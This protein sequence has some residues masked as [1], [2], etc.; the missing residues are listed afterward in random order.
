[1]KFRLLAALIFPVLI[2][3][4]IPLFASDLSLP[5]NSSEP[6][7]SYIPGDETRPASISEEIWEKL[8]SGTLTQQAETKSETQIQTNSPARTTSLTQSTSAL[9]SF[10]SGYTLLDP[11][12]PGS[13][14]TTWETGMNSPG[15]NPQVYRSEIVS[16][17]D[18]STALRQQV[19]GNTYSW[20]TNHYLK[21]TFNLGGAFYPASKL[22]LYLEINRY[23][24]SCYYDGT[25]LI[26]R[27]FRNGNEVGATSYGCGNYHGW[28]FSNP[29]PNG[30]TGI[31]EIPFNFVSGT[32]DSISIEIANYC[33][34]GNNYSI[35]DH[36]M[37][38]GD[39]PVTVNSVQAIPPTL[40]IGIDG[41]A[42]GIVFRAATSVSTTVEFK[43]RGPGGEIF[44]IGS[45]ATS[46]GDSGHIAKLSWWGNLGGSTI[47]EGN[48]EIIAEAGSSSK[49]S[50]F[51][52]KKVNASI[53]GMGTWMKNSKDPSAD[54]PPD[55]KA[56]Q[57]PE[58]SWEQATGEKEGY[59]AGLNLSDPVNI[60]SGNFIL[61]NVDLSLKS[62]L[63]LTLA[64]IY[65]SL[66][67]NIGL[68][69]RGWSSPYLS[70]LEF[71]ASDVV[72]VNSDGSKSFFKYSDGAYVGHISSNLQLSVAT[73]TNL[74]RLFIPGG[75]EWHFDSDGKIIRMAKACCGTGAADSVNIDYNSS[76]TLHKV[77]NNAGQWL[78]FALNSS[79]LIE[80]VT[81][82]AGRTLRYA[83]DSNRNLISFT[84]AINQITTYTYNEDNFL[85]KFTKPGNRA[86][87][88]AYQGSR[89]SGITFPNAASALFNWDFSQQKLLFTSP[90]GVSHEYRFDSSW[91]L[92]GYEIPNAGISK[93]FS[94][95]ELALTNTTNSLG[96]MFSYS[97]NADG[98]LCTSTDPLGNTTSYEWHP[99]FHKLAKKTDP[100]NREWRYNW[101]HRGNL[102]SEINPAGGITSY[103]YDAHNNR[104]SRTDPLGRTVRY[105][106]SSDGSRLLRSIDALGGI[107]S[108]SYDARSNLISSSDQL[109]RVTLY[110]Y[111]ALDRLVKTIH[112]DGRWTEIEYDEAGNIANRRDNLNRVTT[113]TY[114]QADKMISTTRPDGTKH[115]YEYNAAGKKIAEINPLGEKTCFEYDAAGNLVRIVYPDDSSEMSSY[116]TEGQLI[117]RTNELGSVT[118]FEYDPL[119]RMVA[120]IDP[121][122]SR[123][124]QTYDIAGRKVSD[125]DPLLHTTCYAFDVLDRVVST[126]KPDSA[127]IR[128]EYDAVGNLLKT[129]DALAATWSWQYD[130]L[131]RQVKAIQPNGATSETS[132]DAAGQTSAEID[133]LVGVTR[134]SYDSA[135]RIVSRT[136][137]LGN[138]WRNNYDTAGRLV[139]TVNPLGEISSM[140]FDVMDCVISESN[141]AGNITSYEFDAV[142]RRVA[143]TDA[144]GNRSI[145]AYDSRGRVISEV[146]AEGRI[147]QYDYDL[148]GSRTGLTDAACRVWR[149]KFDANGRTLAEIDPIGNRTTYSYNETGARTALVNAR[150][151]ITTFSFDSMNRLVQIDYPNGT[152][153]T[154]S[155]DLTGRELSRSDSN[156]LAAKKYDASGNLISEEFQTSACPG[157]SKSWNYVYDLA[158]NR[159]SAKNPEEE[160]FKY[161]YDALNRLI[162]LDPPGQNNDIKYLYDT[163]GKQ[164]GTEQPGVNTVNSFDAAGRLLSVSHNRDQKSKP[165]ISQR[166]YTYNALGNCISMTDDECGTTVY[167]YDKS[168]WLI[169]VT[170]PEKQVVSYTYNNAGD[171]LSETIKTGHSNSRTVTYSYDAAGRMI[172]KASDTF[173][174][175]SDGNLTISIEED[176]V[177]RNTWSHDNRLLKIEREIECSKHHKKHCR[178]CPKSFEISEEYSYLPNDWRRITRKTAETT[179]FSVY[180]GDDESNEYLIAPKSPAKSWKFGPF[181]WKPKLPQLFS[182]REFISGPGNDDIQTTNYH[183]KS[184][185]M[186]KDALGSTIALT[187]RG[188]NTVAKINYDAWG[189][190]RWP[191]K[192]GHNIA[193][194]KE[195]DLSDLLDRLEGR[196]SFGNIQ[197]DHWH[198][199]RHFAKSFTPYLYTGRRLSAISEQ[200][201]NRNRYY[202]PRYGRFISKD[203]I[204][205]EGG[206]NLWW[207]G[208][209]N[210]PLFKD[211]F[212]QTVE[213]AIDFLEDAG[214]AAG[215]EGAI[216]QEW[217]MKLAPYTPPSQ[218]D[219][220]G[221]SIVSDTVRR[222]H[223]VLP[224]VNNPCVR[225]ALKNAIREIMCGQSHHAISKKVYRTGLKHYKGLSSSFSERDSD[226]IAKAIENAH[227]GY[228][229]WHRE[230]D[231]NVVDYI[232]E[233]G[234]DLS[235]QQFINY[236]MSRYN[237]PDLR[238]RFP[239]GFTNLEYWIRNSNPD[240]DDESGQ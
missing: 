165:P 93:N 234:N 206:N 209:N 18:G 190:F 8:N 226:Y 175:D 131:N 92:S 69:G 184:L 102:I 152:A 164:I 145:T 94:F 59:T 21:R 203:P 129:T 103:T 182:F 159:I 222:I 160:S 162:L 216:Y 3:F 148:A 192:K 179:Y 45:A 97:Y 55:P 225:E 193:P 202:S 147:V 108:F 110:E 115:N 6:F 28:P 70:H 150:N 58:V 33:C 91:Q 17:F 174:Y 132:F 168:G 212:G 133:P 173:E 187:N 219:I 221:L 123:W 22:A 189:N 51:T 229:S 116:N 72:F 231:S 128:N 194:C 139:S 239:F 57:C 39:A 157:V 12:L 181:C 227:V 217:A 218:D 213:K 46:Q 117:N 135:G 200:Y 166:R 98:L 124:E 87:E 11:I 142:G 207:Y 85:S 16:P 104:T 50:N 109:G 56:E 228:A 2:L 204:G 223:E 199:G 143:K 120:T 208:E 96:Q 40:M 60:V 100:L 211:P 86:T 122:G 235:P 177:V 121:A 154:F 107:S 119:G 149:W 169:K 101:C 161:G 84:N 52:V 105:E 47:S 155:Y 99:E 14:G 134:Y 83:Y 176:E 62:R 198:H 15:T 95:S 68:F 35:V 106:Y 53:I 73:D 125:K 13:I 26:I 23:C 27:A 36:I 215:V 178:H 220:Y 37:F 66:D 141:P 64:R 31:L 233:K 61:S 238:A 170:Y 201:F 230:L 171:R 113:Y 163:A 78:E 38:K 197:H 127:I 79:N 5:E 146:D 183:G 82:S 191:E 7:E 30:F 224:M 118:A 144:L 19:I 237:T 153:A 49:T 41:A 130:A 44:P 136:D 24:M 158:G 71:I 180:D 32:F 74:W 188:G 167:E 186:L 9:T 48:Y 236:L 54:V 43:V 112:P 65:N 240:N 210:P 20:C 111:D 88:I 81:D 76:G 42:S 205:F 75:M 114:D 4:S 67:S 195:D 137:A 138:I 140:T 77:S 89:V 196:F 90:E 34:I 126:T 10:P 151:Q 214:K 25:G 156:G 232:N 29:L 1:M 80:N 63:P 185:T 172:S